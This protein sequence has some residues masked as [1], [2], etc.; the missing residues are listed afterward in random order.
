MTGATDGT[1]DAFLRRAERLY[2]ETEIVSCTPDGGERYGYADYA[3]RAA[4]LAN[5]LERV[6]A[7]GDRVGTVCWNHHRHF[8]AYFG[9]PSMGAQLH[10]INPLLPDEDV[11]TI[12]DE[13]ED[14]V[15]LVDPSLVDAV[16]AAAAAD[17]GEN[18]FDAV[19][20]IVVTGPVPDGVAELPAPAVGY[21]SLLAGEPTDYDWPD[22]DGDRPAG[23]C[24]TSGTTGRPKGV[25]YTQAML[26]AHTMAVQSPQGTPHRDDDVLMP[27]VPMFHVNAWGLPYAATAAGA[28]QVLPGPSPG[29]ADLARL[30]AEEGVTLSAGVPTVWLDLMEYADGMSVDL[31]T[32]ER[33][34]VGGSAA[35][36]AMVDWFDERGVEVLHAWGMTE[37]SP[38]GLVNRPKAGTSE[39]DWA[40]YKQGLPVPGLEL[41]IVDDDTG[42]ALPW[43]GDSAGELQVRGPWV[44]SEYVGDAGADAFDGDWLRTGDVATVDPDGY[45][46]IVDRLAD[47]IKSGGEWISSLRLENEIVGLDAVAEAAVVGVSHERWRERPLAVIAPATG[48]DVDAGALRV[49]IED[50]LADRFP[51]WWVPDGVVLVGDLPK[52]AT[53]KFDKVRLRREYA[54]P[55]RLDGP[56]PERDPPDG[57]D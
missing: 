2:P 26:W 48:A 13:A 42:E 22:L 54:D 31:T 9:V 49:A 17:G 4:R 36:A 53:G 5:A 18:A 3:D 24:Y 30:I 14:R 45:V 50:R 39:D 23:L 33:V 10:T 57:S 37:T 43:D 7:P 25:E 11:A 6:V 32:L 55:D 51:R 56:A 46:E 40:V 52:T 41:R 8:E 35:P 12:V 20:R 34:I 15:L 28:K 1:L 38:L 16:V 27:V 29:A 21:E 19:E 47:V 44:A